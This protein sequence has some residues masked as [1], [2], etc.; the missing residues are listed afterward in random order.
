M[1][2]VSDPHFLSTKCLHNIIIEPAAVRPW[3]IL[4]IWLKLM[5]FKFPRNLSIWE[6]EGVYCIDLANM[7][8]LIEIVLVYVQNPIDSFS[9]QYCT[10]RCSIWAV[11]LG[12]YLCH[13]NVYHKS[14]RRSESA[15]NLW[16]PPYVGRN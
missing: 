10:C 13:E 11:N 4:H 7:L 16:D 2:K 3:V 14:F 15:W 12:A 1:I 6:D 5:L 8:T 9:K